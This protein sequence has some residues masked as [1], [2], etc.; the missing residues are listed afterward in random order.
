LSRFQLQSEAIHLPRGAWAKTHRRRLI[1]D[2]RELVGFTEGAFRPYLYPVFTPAG[3]AVTT[4]SPA[5][6]PHHHSI[7]IGAD[8]VHLRMPGSEGRTEEYAYNLYVN[9]TFQGR[10][11]G[12]IV[13]TSI[14]G[15]EAA[16][17]YEVV[18]QLEW[19]GPV[20]WAAPEGRTLLTET[21]SWNFHAGAAF[22]LIDVQSQLTAAQW[23]LAFGPTRH[24]FF[25]F[26]VAEALQVARGGAITRQEEAWLDYSGPVGGGHTAGIALMP[27]SE[28]AKWWWFA[29]DWG[30]VTAGPFRDSARPLLRGE[31]LTL[32]A[33]YVVHD[34]DAACV[35]LRDLHADFVA[36]CGTGRAR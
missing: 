11:A 14:E 30:V 17:R 16:D 2:G 29:T 24:A 10:A 6:H 12:R 9:E 13:E 19:R 5:D 1:C 32:A 8:H 21:R 35:P 36:S 18:Q 15:S 34:G 7:W 20:E 28:G 33:R 31:T 27:W 23:D 25:N 26:R 4:E 22:H 3:F